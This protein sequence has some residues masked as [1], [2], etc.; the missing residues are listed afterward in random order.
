MSQEK[1]VIVPICFRRSKRCRYLHLNIGWIAPQQ[2]KPEHC[3]SCG[4]G[5][6][7]LTISQEDLPTKCPGVKYWTA[8]EKE[9]KEK[10]LQ[11]HPSMV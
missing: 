2:K 8:K 1:K 5:C 10:G 4:K 3:Y 7:Q 9:E 11:L 6:F